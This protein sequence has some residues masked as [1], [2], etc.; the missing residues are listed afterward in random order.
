MRMMRLRK[1]ILPGIFFE[2]VQQEKYEIFISEVVL[3]EIVGADLE[4]QQLL[5]QLIRKYNPV[6]LPYTEDA[7]KIANIYLLNR[8]LPER[9]FEDANHVAIATIHEMDAIIS[10]NLR[11]IA[12]LKRM[13]SVNKINFQNGYL[14]HLELITPME[15]SHD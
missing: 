5:F 15:V 6:D 12:N 14:K 1:G 13:E 9:S 7:E 3:R 4:K 2:L 10:W 8:I 11:H